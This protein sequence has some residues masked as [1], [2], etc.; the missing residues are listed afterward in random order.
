MTPGERSIRD[1]LWGGRLTPDEALQLVEAELARTET[2]SLLVL[3]GTLIQLP[4][5][6]RL[7]LDE[8]RESFERAIQL[9]PDDPEAYEELSHYF[10]AVMPDHQKAKQFYRLALDKGA[11]PAC[12][13]ALQEL[14]ASE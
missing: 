10:D 6:G 12:Q 7:T 5:S 1:G 3:R 9:A 8:A 4:E 13:E 11:G 14:L 2:A